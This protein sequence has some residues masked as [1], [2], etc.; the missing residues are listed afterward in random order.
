MS[1]AT[2]SVGVPLP[3]GVGV[4]VGVFSTMPEGVVVGVPITIS[5]GVPGGETSP[6]VG[7]TVGSVPGS[8]V[9]LG[10][11]VVPGS[12]VVSGIGVVLGSGSVGVGAVTPGS[13][14]RRH[15]AI[16]RGR[17]IY[18]GLFAQNVPVGV[19][20]ISVVTAVTTLDNPEP[21]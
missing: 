11:G 17:H 15:P 3:L 16:S 6:I 19:F 20:I 13:T 14:V 12:G 4:G 2:V 18:T 21:S 8:G 9:V 1:V 5:V 10:S 7:V